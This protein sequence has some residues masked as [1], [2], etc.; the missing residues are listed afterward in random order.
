MKILAVLILTVCAATVHAQFA[1]DS[2][3]NLRMKLVLSAT[4]QHRVLS[5]LGIPTLG[6][7]PMDMEQFG[8]DHLLLRSVRQGFRNVFTLPAKSGSYARNAARTTS[9]SGLVRVTASMSDVSA[10]RFTEAQ[11]DTTIITL[12]DPDFQRLPT[13]TQLLVSRIVRAAEDAD[14]FLHQAFRGA[15]Y[16]ALFSSKPT[17][18]AMYNAVTAPW[19]E[20]RGGQ[21]ASTHPFGLDALD[22]I[23]RKG[24][25]FCGVI[26]TAHLDSAIAAWLADTS[27]A[28][29]T[30]N[31]QIALAGHAD[32]VEE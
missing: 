26:L 12:T 5:D 9:L 23:D 7:E 25:A 31:G 30:P 27:V 28:S 11:T 14:P 16:D 10:G 6:Y 17:P 22:Q 2:L 4:E 29:T 32:G 8:S 1:V 18:T 19:R 3:A 13:A 20:D 21:V 15:A 24:L